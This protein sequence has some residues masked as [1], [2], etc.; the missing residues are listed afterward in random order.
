MYFVRH[1]FD[2][3]HKHSEVDKPTLDD[4]FVIFDTGNR[5]FQQS[6]GIPMVTNCVP[7]LIDLFLY[8]YQ[9]EFVQNLL[10]EKKKSLAVTF[11]FTF[12]YIEDVL[13]INN[14]NFHSCEDSIYVTAN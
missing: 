9:A 13:S 7:L 4:I 11:N 5:V 8:S 12:R 10:H 6:V 3:T 1:H 14:I 2:L